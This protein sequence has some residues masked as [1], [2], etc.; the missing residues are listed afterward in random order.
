MDAPIDLGRSYDGPTPVCSDAVP[1]KSYPS[2]YLTLPPGT[3][4]P[5]KGKIEFE[6]EVVGARLD[7]PSDGPTKLCLDLSLK[8][9]V[10]AEESDAAKEYDVPSVADALAAYASQKKG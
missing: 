4:V 1:H 8:R 10:E 7:M 9:L 2:V 3:R 6:Y 5:P